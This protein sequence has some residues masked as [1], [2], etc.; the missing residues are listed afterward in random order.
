MT[1]RDIILSI[2]NH[3]ENIVPSWTMAFFNVQTA[4]RLLGESNMPND[5]DPQEEYKM[6]SSNKKDQIRK[7]K[8]AKVIDDFAIG[9]GKGA[10]FAFGHG[11]PGEF[12]DKLIKKEK[13]ICISKYE[14]GVKKEVKYKPYFYQHYDYPLEILSDISDLILPNANDEKRYDGLEKEVKFYKNKGYFTYANINGFFS[15]IHYYLYP[16]DKLFMDMIL[17]KNMLKNLLSKQ[18]TR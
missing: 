3:E 18:P 15:G 12:M 1:K 11:G 7:L 6:G 9:V 13:N 4:R 2:L 5:I 8:Y 16:Y 17:E 14:T 10:N